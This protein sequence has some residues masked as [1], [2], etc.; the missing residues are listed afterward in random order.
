MGRNYKLMQS[1][2]VI[3]RNNAYGKGD[4]RGRAW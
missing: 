2:R 3:T 4:R 1:R